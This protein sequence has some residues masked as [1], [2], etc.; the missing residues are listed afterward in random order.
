MPLIRLTLGGWDDVSHLASIAVGGVKGH[1]DRAIDDDRAEVVVAVKVAVCM[2]DGPN[3]NLQT[4]KHVR[5][6][7]LLS[8]L[9]AHKSHKSQACCMWAGRN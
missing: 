1:V 7:C 8:R 5:S 4:I 6:P 3:D 9:H 2:G